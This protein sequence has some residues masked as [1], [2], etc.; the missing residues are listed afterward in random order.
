MKKK[1]LALIVAM[2]VACSTGAF[3]LGLGIQGNW[4]A[5]NSGSGGA[6]LSI[7]L[8]E[9]PLIFTIGYDFANTPTVSIWGD[10]WL[11]NNQIGNL[12][13]ASINWFLGVGFF[14]NAVFTDPFGFNAGLRIPLGLNMFI[15]KKIEPFIE[16]A[17]SLGVSLIPNI[18]IT[19]FQFPISLGLRIWF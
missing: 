13:G 16:V 8:D 15:A 19:N 12:G 10:Y 7:K 17:P 14:T 3:A 18:A 5:G 1:V 9:T 6:A 11:F 2:M 4:N